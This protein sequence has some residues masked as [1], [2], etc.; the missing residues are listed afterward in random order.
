[1]VIDGLR[2]SPAAPAARDPRCDRVRGGAPD[3]LGFSEGFMSSGK[4]SRG[5]TADLRL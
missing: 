4:H 2:R 5:S 1:L 3:R